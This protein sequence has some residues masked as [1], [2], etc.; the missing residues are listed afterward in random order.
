MTLWLSL[1]I[2]RLLQ[3]SGFVESTSMEQRLINTPDTQLYNEFTTELNLQIS[4][5]KQ[6]Y[7][8]AVRSQ[9][10]I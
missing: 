8:L 10:E 9:P 2:E 7:S 1:D 4:K 5:P 6:M 3:V